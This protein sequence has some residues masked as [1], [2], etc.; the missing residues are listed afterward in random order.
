MGLLRTAC[1]NLTIQRQSPVGNLGL[2]RDL[3][4]AAINSAFMSLFTVNTTITVRKF[5]LLLVTNDE[6]I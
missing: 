4:L 2:N 6:T 1:N 3:F 5:W